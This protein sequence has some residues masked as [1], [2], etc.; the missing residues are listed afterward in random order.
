MPSS[1][2]ASSSIPETSDSKAGGGSPSEDGEVKVF[3]AATG[4]LVVEIKNAHS[5]TCFGL[6]FSPDGK[7]LATGGADK[8]VKV[9]ELPSG[10]FVKSFEGHTHHVMDVGW[11]HDGKL[12][13]SAGA[14]NTIKVWDFD[15]GEQTRT[16]NAH[17]QQITRLQ[18]VGRTSQVLTCSGDRNARYW[19][20]DNGG[21]G[22]TFGGSTDF[23]YAIG[24]SP[25]GKVVATGG[26]EGVVRLYNGTNGQLIKALA[27]PGAESKK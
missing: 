15:K 16:I 9:F 8:F 26:Q 27:P 19:N 13:A 10:Q 4:Q 22:I 21:G 11:K 2:G 23:L 18:F 24:V 14:D 7:M 6:A 12:L 5:D 1:R 3:D 25:D 17:G 20:V